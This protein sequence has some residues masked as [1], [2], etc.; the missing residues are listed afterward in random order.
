MGK[1]KFLKLFP[2]EIATEVSQ[3]E[4]NG[5][6]SDELCDTVLTTHTEKKYEMDVTEVEADIHDVMKKIIDIKEYAYYNLGMKLKD[7]S[8]DQAKC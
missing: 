4:W 1:I 6:D 7:V 2:I 5:R 8:L 3:Y